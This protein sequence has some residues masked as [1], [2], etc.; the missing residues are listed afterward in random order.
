MFSQSFQMRLCYVMNQVAEN[1]RELLQGENV[2]NTLVGAANFRFTFCSCGIK[3]RL[4]CLLF[5]FYVLV[6]FGCPLRTSL[7]FTL[8]Q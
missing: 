5:S 2:Y 8:R 7:D 4:V 3:K 6:I 1:Y